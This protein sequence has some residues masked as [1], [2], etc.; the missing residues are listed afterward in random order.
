MIVII[1]ISLWYQTLAQLKEASSLLYTRIRNCDNWKNSIRDNTR[2]SCSYK[3]D[4][5]TLTNSLNN[6][7]SNIRASSVRIHDKIQN[8]YILTF[9]LWLLLRATIQ[10]QQQHRTRHGA[11]S[12]WYF[13]ISCVVGLQ[14]WIDSSPLN[15]ESIH[16]FF[17][18]PP[19]NVE[20]ERGFQS[21]RLRVCVLTER[22]AL[23]MQ[24]A[25][26]VN[27]QLL[28][29]KYL[30]IHSIRTLK[31][32]CST[33]VRGIYVNKCAYMWCIHY[34]TYRSCADDRFE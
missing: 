13:A 2:Q 20:A 16:L 29:D 10:R 7:S 34:P 3:K 4:R 9:G 15:I 27:K 19:I 26:I 18:Q 28:A 5:Q 8:Q 14:S 1:I 6:H 31:V 32:N 12:R 30:K 22:A 17:V 24:C 23:H 21:I 11:T 25:C 33:S